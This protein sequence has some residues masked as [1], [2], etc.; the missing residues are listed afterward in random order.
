MLEFRNV[1]VHL[2]RK[3]IVKNINFT[4]KK[5]KITVLLGKN[6]SGKST[7][8]RAAGGMLKCN[9]EILWE[10]RT[11]APAQRARLAAFLPQQLP[12]TE[13]TVEEV[14]A[15]GRHPYTGLLGK[16]GAAD[17]AAVARALS[18]MGLEGLCERSVATL[19]GGEKQRVFLA[20]ALAQQTPLLVLD[21]PATFMDVAAAGEVD[22]LCRN[23]RAEGRTVL[24]VMHDLSRAVALADEI[25]VLEA[26]KI[27]FAGSKQNCLEQRVLE[28]C[29]GVRRIQAEEHIFFI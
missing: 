3:D 8:I 15:L 9:G 2:G 24:A 16:T 26:G 28:R 21:E 13:L 7:L 14:V 6:G 11:L 25:V 27:I 10:G 12:E 23:L 4:V 29:F 18:A 5:G 1:S 19:S 20:Q 17:R 22:A